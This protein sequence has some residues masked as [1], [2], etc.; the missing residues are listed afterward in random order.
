[1]VELTRGTLL[2]DR[3]RVVRVLGQGG[4]GMVL[5]VMHEQLGGRFALKLMH[6][7]PAR[8]SEMLSRFENE[9]RLAARIMSPHLVRVTDLGRLPSGEPFLVMDYLE[10]LD[11]EQIIEQTVEQKRWLTVADAVQWVLVG[12]AGLLEAEHFV[13]D[14][15]DAIG[16]ERVVEALEHGDRTNV[17][18]GYTKGLV[19]ETVGVDLTT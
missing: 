9:A 2:A 18:A 4:M 7:E 10:G 14:G 8:D 11:L 12:C 6:A 16:A 1:M 3:Y 17:D 5:E 15:R 19:K 13:D